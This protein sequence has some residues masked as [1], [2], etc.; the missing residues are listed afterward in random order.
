M[1]NPSL[2]FDQCRRKFRRELLIQRQVDKDYSEA[3]LF[4]DAKKIDNQL[5][6]AGYELTYQTEWSRFYH[7]KRNAKRSS[8]SSARRLEGWQ[9]DLNLTCMSE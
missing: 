2:S 5:I 8:A 4:N 1:K 9:S 3:R 7:E 6:A